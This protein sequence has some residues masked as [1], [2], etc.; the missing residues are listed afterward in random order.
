VQAPHLPNDGHYA[1]PVL[2][3]H[4][5]LE[6]F[7]L[8]LNPNHYAESPPMCSILTCTMTATT[9]FQSGWPGR[10]TLS[11]TWYLQCGSQQQQQRSNGSTVTCS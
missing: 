7:C 9:R 10:G 2:P 5:L 6:Q 4:P 11:V 8:L 1:L 3:S